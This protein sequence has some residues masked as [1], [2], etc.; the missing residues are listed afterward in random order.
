MGY[1]RVD[2]VQDR[3]YNSTMVTAYI[4]EDVDGTNRTSSGGRCSWMERHSYV[5]ELEEM[6][7]KY[8]HDAFLS[9]LELAELR[10]TMDGRRR[11]GNLP[12]HSG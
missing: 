3:D 1:K 12:Y 9:D 6:L 4:Y 10:K 7:K 11:S 5:V 2:I 8:S